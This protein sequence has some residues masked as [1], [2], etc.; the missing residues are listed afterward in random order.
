RSP[1][2]GQ[3]FAATRNAGGNYRGSGNGFEDLAISDLQRASRLLLPRRQRSWLG[4]HRNFRLPKCAL[5]GIRDQPR[6]CLAND[7]YHSRCLEGF[8]DRADLSAA[9]RSDAVPLFGNR[10]GETTVQRAFPP[11][12]GIRSVSCA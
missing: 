6:T 1:I 5:P 12:D 8:S 11:V 7:E 10:A 4:E 9:S 2:D 3:I